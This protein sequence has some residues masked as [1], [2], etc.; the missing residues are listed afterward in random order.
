M[1]YS[2]EEIKEKVKVVADRYDIIEILLFGSYFDHVPTDDSDL[3]IVVKYGGNCRGLKRIRFINDLEAEL[4]K[5][6]D[7]I[8]IQFPP[9]FMKEIDLYDE[10]RKIYA[11]KL[12]FC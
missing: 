4:N 10:R 9:E 8:N 1:V 12:N 6:V 3:D 5:E 11:K 2:I 7:V